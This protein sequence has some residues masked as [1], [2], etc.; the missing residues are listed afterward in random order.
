LTI[1]T[2]AFYE[3]HTQLIDTIAS[4][5]LGNMRTRG[6]ETLDIE[7]FAFGYGG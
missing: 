6:A 4:A 2:N 1:I 7:D 3:A 5:A